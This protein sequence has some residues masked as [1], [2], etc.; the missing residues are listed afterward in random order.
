MVA[1][2]ADLPLDRAL[3][4]LAV[5]ERPGSTTED[6]ILGELDHLARGVTLRQGAPV[7]E[8]VARLNH[9]LFV[10]LGFTGDDT[11]YDAPR[12]SLIDVVLSRR[13][14]LPILLS[15]VMIE[16]GR[17]LG[18]AIE[19]VGFPQHFLVAPADAQPRFYVDA[20]NGGRILRDDQLKA[21]FSRAYGGL[22][23]LK[24]WRQVTGPVSNRDVMIRVCNNLAITYM[25]RQDRRGAERL[26]ARLVELGPDDPSL[27]MTLQRFLSV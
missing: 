26:H 25:R 8:H 9:R 5:A 2:L 16:V 11:D 22:P 15:C 21:H 23:D 1:S 14:G 19:P 13:K 3:A 6:A 20:F 18:V 24:V 10:E 7:V 12:N 17:R 4:Q 27:L